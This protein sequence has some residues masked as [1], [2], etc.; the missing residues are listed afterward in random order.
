MKIAA[1]LFPASL[2]AF[3]LVCL[4][5]VS[6]VQAARF[7]AEQKADL[8]AAAAWLN[9][10]TTLKSRFLQISHDGGFL[11][12]DFMLRRPGRL[13]FEYDPP[14][15]YLVLADGFWLYFLDRELGEPQNWPI[16]DTPLGVLVAE[17]V[18][19][20]DNP[21]VE[22]VQRKPGTL[23]IT[24]RDQKRPDDGTVTLVFSRQ[25]LALRQWKVVDAQGQRTTVTLDKVETGMYLAPTL[26]VMPFKKKNDPMR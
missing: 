13:R 11:Q 25:P 19:L 12:G 16:N 18:S 9:G 3:C 7:N 8:K 22:S 5:S 2:L 4:V 26:F 15:P 17:E 23:A 10:I 14:S 24:I 20:L 1:R 6:S 21:D